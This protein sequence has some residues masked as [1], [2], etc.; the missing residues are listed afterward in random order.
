[1]VQHV[2][3]FNTQ[4]QVHGLRRLEVLHERRVQAVKPRPS[5]RVP[6]EGSEFDTLSGRSGEVRIRCHYA[7]RLVAGSDVGRERAWESA[8]DLVVVLE[9]A[10]GRT[11]AGIKR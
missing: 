9:N 10:I 6:P 4:L 1:M 3:R 5:E 2:Q 11:E 7:V 8:A